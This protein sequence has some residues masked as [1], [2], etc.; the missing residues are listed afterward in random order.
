LQK[1]FFFLSEKANLCVKKLRKIIRYLHFFSKRFGH[2][3]KKQYLCSRF[4]AKSSLYI[5]K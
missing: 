5:C 4:R 1:Y 2:V 3:K